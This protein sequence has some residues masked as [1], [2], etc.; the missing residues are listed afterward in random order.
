ME[1]E[2][3]GGRLFLLVVLETVV[4]SR[5]KVLLREALRSTMVLKDLGVE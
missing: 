4:G 2:Q 1:A 3:I 5:G